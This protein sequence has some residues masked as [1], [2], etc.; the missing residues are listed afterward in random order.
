MTYYIVILLSSQVHKEVR[1]DCLPELT[2]T[3][4]YTQQVG[5]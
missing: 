1:A 3:A 4:T 2:E 5:F